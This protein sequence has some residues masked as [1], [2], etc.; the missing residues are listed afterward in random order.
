M[1][2]IKRKSAVRV[3]TATRR[4]SR[5]ILKLSRP[6][7]S[8]RRASSR[9]S[10]LKLRTS[11]QR[12]QSSAY[13]AYEAGLTAGKRVA[14]EVEALSNGSIDEA[15]DRER[16]ENNLNEWFAG[17]YP[18]SRPSCVTALKYCKSYQNGYAKGRNISTERLRFPL[19]LQR[20]ASA[21]V[22]ACNEEHTLG[23]VLSE[24]SQLPL[25]EIVVVLNG[26]T[27]HSFEVVRRDSRAIIVH[28]PQRLG[29]DV[30]R[31]IGSMIAS[32]DIVLFAD[33]DM[34][35]SAEE[36]APYLYAVDGGTD[37]VLNNITPHLPKFDRMDGVSRC[38]WLLNRA[39]GRPDLQ[40]SSLTAVPHALSRRAIETVGAQALAVPP[41][42]QTIAILEGLS[43]SAPCTT[44]VITRNR[45][46]TRNT[47]VNNKMAQ[48]ILGD[49]MEALEEAQGRQGP[50]L[51]WKLSSRSE[52]AKVRNRS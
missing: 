34:A 14:V 15:W 17:R 29:H 47:G 26:C 50:R 28:Y 49:H 33:G 46:R 6:S 21:V 41:K 24:L 1:R 43:I 39:L 23:K 37:V 35:L 52:L 30:G 32:G 44:D 12:E 45:L 3:K 2:R 18:S 16:F 48:L 10:R 9:K 8:Q 42:A 36:Y 4:K 40:A 38:K 13:E 20:R 51:F 11:R 25:T 27:D 31:G 19:P 5:S 7:L 22:V